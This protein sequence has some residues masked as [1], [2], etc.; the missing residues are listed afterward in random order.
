[1]PKRPRPLIL[2]TATG[3]AALTCLGTGLWGL[4]YWTELEELQQTSVTPSLQALPSPT[5]TPTLQASSQPDQQ[6]LASQLD[7]VLAS[8]GQGTASAQ[9]ILADG[10]QVYAQESNSLRIPASNMKMLVNYA[11]QTSH[12]NQRLTTSVSQLSDSQLVLVAG[13]DSLLVPGPSNPDEVVGRAGIQTLAEQTL[14]ALTA[15]GASNQSYSVSLDTS[16]FSGPATNPDWAQED[17]DSGFLSPVTPLAFYSHYSPAANGSRSDQRPQDAPR[18]VLDSLIDQL[19]RLGQEGGLSFSASDQQVATEGVTLA[20]VQS[21]TLAEQ[22]N[23]MMLESDNSLAEVL[24][25]NLSALEGGDGSTRGAIEAIQQQLTARGLTFTY[26]QADISG[27]STNNRLTTEFLNELTLRAVTGDAQER[28]TLRSLPVAG[29]S[30]TLGLANRFND[31][32]ELDGRGL[33]RAKTGTL[34]EALSLSGY[35]VGDSGQVYIF[36]VILND[37]TDAEAAKSTLDSFAA[38]LTR[39]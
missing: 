5:S 38:T 26:Q 15:K 22:A 27:L 13:G 9:V 30:G 20:S 4:P 12:P 6:A 28:A 31:D 37:L 23:L 34:N 18:Q 29:L 39:Y 14:E 32:P 21:A 36:S 1:M 35:A 10:Q 16:I 24:G 33:V 7:A 8:L 2:W 25:R 3:C 17:L 11:L 19:N